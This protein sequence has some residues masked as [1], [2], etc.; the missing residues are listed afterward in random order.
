MKINF[1]PHITQISS[2]VMDKSNDK[3]GGAGSN[4]YDRQKKKEK[5]EEVI[6]VTDENVQNAVEQFSVDELTKSNGIT[7]TQEGHGP[8]LKVVLKDATGGVLRSVSGEEFL[9]LREAVQSGKRSGK[10]LDQKA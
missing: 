10:L 5:E 3:Q 1:Y 2:K 6:E 8:G 7:A 9:K 4:A